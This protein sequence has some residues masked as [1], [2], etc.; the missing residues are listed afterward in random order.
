MPLLKRGTRIRYTVTGV[1]SVAEANRGNADGVRAGID[2]S[3]VR[4][5]TLT[6]PVAQFAA[7]G[8]AAVVLLGGGAILLMRHIGTTEAIRDAKQL[9]FITGRGIV[10][11]NVNGLY[12]GDPHAVARVDR[13]VRAHVLRAPVVRVKIWTPDGRIVYSDDRRLIGH[14]YTLAQDDLEALEQGGA[15]A[16]VSDLA[17]PENRFERRFHKLLEV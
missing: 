2:R 3:L 11:P 17:R 14:R 12:R 5:L 7:S 6:R 8:L 13:A 1:A 10:E 4:R 9:G 16:D 15:F